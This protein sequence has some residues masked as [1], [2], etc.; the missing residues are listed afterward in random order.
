MFLK[1]WIKESGPCSIKRSIE[2]T[3][4]IMKVID[5]IQ[6]DS[7]IVVMVICIRLI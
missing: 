7:A 1:D 3:H 6:Q 5:K 2:S 4:E